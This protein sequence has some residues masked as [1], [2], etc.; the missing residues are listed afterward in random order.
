VNVVYDSKLGHRYYQSTG[1]GQRQ[2]DLIVCIGESEAEVTN[3]TRLHLR[4]CTV[5]AKYRQT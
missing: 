4:Y 5:E 2:Q 1:I 3:N